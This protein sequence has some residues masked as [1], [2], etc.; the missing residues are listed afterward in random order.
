MLMLFSICDCKIIL[1]K[2][3]NKDQ[4]FLNIVQFF[5]FL[6][7]MG[8]KLPI[9]VTVLKKTECDEARGRSVEGG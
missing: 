9:F 5:F 8:E 3:G 1:K 7:L 2:R 4:K 6:R